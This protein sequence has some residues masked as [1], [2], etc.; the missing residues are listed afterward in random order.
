MERCISG[1][2]GICND[3]IDRAKVG[4]NFCDACFAFVIIGNIPFIG[5]D[6]GAFGKFGGSF[7]V[8][9]VGCGYRIAC[10]LKSV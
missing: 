9:G 2:A 5:F 6:A 7:I 3:Y 10:I 1:D 8:A 4:F